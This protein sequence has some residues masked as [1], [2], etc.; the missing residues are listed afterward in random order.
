MPV[1]SSLEFRS[2]FL[3][4]DCSAVGLF[5]LGSAALTKDKRLLS[6]MWF[7]SIIKKRWIRLEAVWS[8][9]PDGTSC[10]TQG[11][12]SKNHIDLCNLSFMNGMFCLLECFKLVYLRFGHISYHAVFKWKETFRPVSMVYSAGRLRRR[13][14]WDKF[15]EAVKEGSLQLR[16]EQVMDQRKL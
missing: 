4:L 2:H 5:S 7:C 6:R 1:I 9:N 16:S 15:N 13:C 10:V 14:V 8:G 11:R 12:N 3:I